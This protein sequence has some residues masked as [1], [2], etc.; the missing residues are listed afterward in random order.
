MEVEK[1]KVQMENGQTIEVAVTDKSVDAI[2]IALGEGI[3]NVKCRLLPTR[4]KLAYAGSVMGREM[5]YER[6]VKD[7]QADIAHIEQV[8]FQHKYR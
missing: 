2:Y 8:N 3:H 7:V 1:I 4:N 6:S 5:I